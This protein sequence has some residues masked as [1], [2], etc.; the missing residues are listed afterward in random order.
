MA[1]HE[2]RIKRDEVHILLAMRR[3]KENPEGRTL[4]VRHVCITDDFEKEAEVL[5]AKCRASSQ[6]EGTWRINRTVNKRSTKKASLLLQHK[7][8]DNPEMCEYLETAWKTCLLDSKCKVSRNLLVD[9]DTKDSDKLMNIYSELSFDKV[10]LIDQAETP[11]GFHLVCEVF[12]KRILDNIEDAEVKKDAYIF[13]ER[14][15]I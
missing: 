6:A 12:D 4:T 10:K 13:Q 3:R 11:N 2:Q 15:V 5:K 1:N 14:F 8:L 9:I 7:L